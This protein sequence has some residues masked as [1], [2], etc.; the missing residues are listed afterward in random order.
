M[1][2]YEVNPN[3][4]VDHSGCEK[5]LH[6]FKVITRTSLSFDREEVVRWCPKCGA[7]VVDMDFDNRTN[8]G[9]YKK[10]E[11]P[12]ITCKYGFENYNVGEINKKPNKVKVKVRTKRK[13]VR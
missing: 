3:R 13:S 10:I 4:I 2:K 1:P 9:Y 7:I 12:E 8:P 6:P 11:Y 5:G